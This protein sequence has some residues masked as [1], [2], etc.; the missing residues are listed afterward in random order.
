MRCGGERGRRFCANVKIHRACNFRRENLDIYIC[1]REYFDFIR[2]HKVANVGVAFP[3]SNSFNSV[4]IFHFEKCC[5]ATY[6]SK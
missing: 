5:Q 2:C 6:Y 1:I 4:I 3:L